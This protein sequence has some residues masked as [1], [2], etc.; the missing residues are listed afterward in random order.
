[1]TTVR[2]S[3]LMIRSR[4]GRM[5]LLS[6]VVLL[7]SGD[8]S[9]TRPE[10]VLASG[11][12]TQVDVHGSLIGNSGGADDKFY[13]SAP[14]GSQI[15]VAI[16]QT[17][18]PCLTGGKP[19][20][21]RSQFFVEAYM[22]NGL[23]GPSSEVAACY[24]TLF[25]RANGST[26]MLKVSNYANGFL[27][28]YTMSIEGPVQWLMQLTP[29]SASGSTCEVG[30]SIVI[31]PQ[32]PSPPTVGLDIVF[33]DGRTVPAASGNSTITVPSSAEITLRAVALDEQGVSN[34]QI[35]VGRESCVFSSD[36]VTCSGPGL[37]GT[38]AAENPD[39]G[40]PG[41]HGCTERQVTF[42]V[43]AIRTETSSES[44]EVHAVG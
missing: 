30:R 31:P 41:Q 16:R 6:L 29:L 38:P 15:S 33:P 37:L 21:R 24:Q 7:F 3:V 8:S 22:G 43:T 19:G 13:F 18:E 14:A 1:M 42:K 23:E 25:F 36:R 39:R 35:W 11:L 20:E 27:S 4:I 5:A 44:F 9:A 26:L 10:H 34:I 40:R 12:G 28:D 17:N 2:R 32:D